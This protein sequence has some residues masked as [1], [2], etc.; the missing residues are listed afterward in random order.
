MKKE[1]RYT[2]TY[3]YRYPLTDMQ[4]DTI[5]SRCDLP[6]NPCQIHEPSTSLSLV[7]I[8]IIKISSLIPLNAAALAQHT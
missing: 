8:D 3:I 1:Y 7:I 5:P 6:F 2:R 4:N